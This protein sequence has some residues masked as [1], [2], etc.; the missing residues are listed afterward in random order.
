MSKKE[1][2]LRYLGLSAYLSGTLASFLVCL[3]P[4][5]FSGG[6]MIKGLVVLI[7]L[8]GAAVER[9]VT[10]LVIRP[11]MYYTRILQLHLLRNLIDEQTRI[12][13]TQ[14]LTVEYFLG[15]SVEEQSLK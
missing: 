11:F 6:S 9:V 8:V 5:I 2:L 3:Y 4:E 10:A 12:R 7:A 13:V 1:K 14:E 15:K